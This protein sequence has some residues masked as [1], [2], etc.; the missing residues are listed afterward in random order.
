MSNGE[1]LYSVEE[2]RYTLAKGTHLLQ[3]TRGRAVS[4]PRTPKWFQEDRS[5][6]LWIQLVLR[7]HNSGVQGFHS[8][9]AR[10][11]D[12]GAGRCWVARAGS[13]STRQTRAVSHIIS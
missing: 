9:V 1:D 3:Q 10:G 2:Y 13:G 6:D 12:C 8:V 4:T 5:G 7:I 11:G